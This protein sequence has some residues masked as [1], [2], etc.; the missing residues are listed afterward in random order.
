MRLEWAQPL[1]APSVMKTSC[2]VHNFLLF[3]PCSFLLWSSVGCVEHVLN[4]MSNYKPY[5]LVFS[6][7][8]IVKMILK[9]MPKQD[10]YNSIPNKSG[11][12]LYTVALNK[13]KYISYWDFWISECCGIDL[14][15]LCF[16]VMVF[17]KR[18]WTT[19]CYST[20]QWSFGEYGV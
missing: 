18:G 14:Q 8:Y 4:M 13:W 16:F 11:E 10:A 2:E 12:L 7:P 15:A 1:T 20:I 6:W 19:L 9:M 3:L 5:F 17:K